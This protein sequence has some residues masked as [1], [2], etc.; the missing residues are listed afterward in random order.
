[1][2][3]LLL[4]PPSEKGFIR[5]GRWTRT[6]RAN[7]S[8][9]PIWLAYC[10]GFLQQH[11]FNCELIDASV[12]GINYDS[13]YIRVKYLKPDVI[14]YYWCYDNMEDDLAF[15]DVLAKYSR[16]ILVGPWSLCATDVLQKTKRIHVMTYGE[17]EHTCLELLTTNHYSNVN[18]VIWRN[19]IDN[20]IHINPRR[21][22]CSTQEL[23][24]MPFVTSVYRQFLN[25]K[26]YRQTS[27]KFPFIDLFGARGCP[28]NCTYCV[29]TRAFQNGPSYRPR[30]IKN[31]INE[32][33]YIKN[34]LPEIKQVFFQD[35]TLPPK[36]ATE[37]S[38]A[39]LNEKL[40]ICWGG[41]S[42][43][44]QSY[45]TLKLMKESGC[46]TLHIGY[47]SPIQSNLNLIQ[48]GIEVK[49]MK[50]F[51]N[52]IKK[53]NMWTSATF[54]LFPWMTEKEIK[55]TIKWAK[56]IKPKRINFI[57]AQAYPNTP[58]FNKLKLF[59]EHSNTTLPTDNGPRCVGKLMSTEEMKKWEQWSFKQFYFYN[60]RFY[61]EV[62]KSPREW[63]QV[64]KDAEGLLN[65]LG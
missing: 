17:F 34:S 53:L 22:L 38:Q 29:W 23:D 49:Q 36:R 52:N 62:L 48:K 46:R 27:L 24:S 6:T 37:L 14:L 43:A 55:F 56:S 39:I 11:G 65:F 33:W 8:W 21:P 12:E 57:Q 2:N 51:A 42:R 60:P 47:E 40:N 13:V 41:Y 3:V 1:M 30:S 16:V 54:M 61:Y 32:L 4:N 20:T 9:Y 18:G 64:L 7:Q 50:E 63:K 10:T 58:Y 28:S 25:P 15:A 19:H 45:E 26:N 35:D 5:S 59:S 44:E 31:V